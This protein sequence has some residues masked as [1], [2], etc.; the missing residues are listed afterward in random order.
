MHLY[1]KKNIYIF[2]YIFFQFKTNWPMYQ[3]VPK[4]TKIK[5]LYNKKAIMTLWPKGTKK[6]KYA[7]KLKF[8]FQNVCNCTKQCVSECV[9]TKRN[10]NKAIFFLITTKYAIVQRIQIMLM[11]NK[12]KKTIHKTFF[13]MHCYQKLPQ[14]NSIFP[15]KTNYF[16]LSQSMLLH[17]KNNEKM[18]FLIK[19]K[20]K[21]VDI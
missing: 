3:K 20:K 12:I 16:F 4:K 7:P 8:G 2:I 1:K 9:I 6:Y 18:Y 21:I 10:T 5:N 17:E 14:K 15:K 13:L 19:K 11:Q